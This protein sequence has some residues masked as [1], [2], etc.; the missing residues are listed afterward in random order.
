MIKQLLF[1]LVFL[2][3]STQGREF[4]LE[5]LYQ[6]SLK[7]HPQ[8]KILKSKVKEIEFAIKELKSSYYPELSA[9]VGGERRQAAQ[10][11]SIDTNRF[12]AEVRVKYNLF[13]FNKSADEIKTL[14]K[15]LEKESLDFNWWQENLYREMK[16]QYTVAQSLNEKLQILNEELRT[17]SILKKSVQKRRKSGLIGKSDILDIEL[18]RNQLLTSINDL[19]EELDHSMDKLRKLSFIEHSDKIKVMGELPHHHYSLKL[20]QLIEKAKKNN[21][22]IKRSRYLKQAQLSELNKANKNYLPEVNLSGRYG[23]MRIDE[24]YVNSTNQNEGLIGVYVNI[25]LFSGG[26]KKSTRQIYEEKYQQRLQEAKLHE[27]NESI[28]LTHKFELLEKVHQ[29]VDLLEDGLKRGK[30]YFQN[31][32]SEYKRG[33][34]NSLDLVSSR[35]RLVNL[36]MNLIEAKTKY[37]ITL[38]NIEELTGEKLKENL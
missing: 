19:N 35:D 8:V 20:S 30:S 38:L 11:S 1:L 18:R 5:E 32:M 3:L 28:E 9:V 23:R 24:Q 21:I 16:A 6:H 34:K 14:E 25:P 13:R 7:N 36:N 37:I 15:I 10:D 33:V 2:S 4:N 31:V 17:N 22:R 26:S 29:K 27:N 12:V